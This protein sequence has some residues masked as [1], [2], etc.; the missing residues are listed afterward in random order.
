MDPLVEMAYRSP[1]IRALREGTE[2]VATASTAPP[3]LSSP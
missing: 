3:P 2:I 1:V